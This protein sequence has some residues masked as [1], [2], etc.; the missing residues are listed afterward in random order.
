ML[1]VPIGLKVMDMNGLVT[2]NETAVCVWKMLTEDR[3]LDELA[4]AVVEEFDVA[5]ERAS[6][7][8]QV[9]IDEITRMGLLE[10]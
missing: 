6:A 9:F 7:D 8:V 1:L 4:A 5:P 2:M 10:P 3:T